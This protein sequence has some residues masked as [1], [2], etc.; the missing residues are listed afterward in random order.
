MGLGVKGANTRM[1]IRMAQVALGD[2]VLDVGCGTGDLTLAVQIAAGLSGLA[3]GIDPAPEGIAVAQGKAKRLYLAAQFTVGLI[4]KI[5]FPDATFDLAIS[6]ILKHLAIAAVGHRLIAE[7]RV[8]EVP[9]MLVE[10]GFVEV[11]S[12]PTRSVLL[13]FFSGRKPAA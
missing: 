7:S 3:C 2:K 13:A 1:V 11:A 12:G 6:P 4:E 8:W 10:A 5:D 9:Q